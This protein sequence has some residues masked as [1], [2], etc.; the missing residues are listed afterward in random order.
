MQPAGL[1]FGGAGTVPASP[2]RITRSPCR[3]SKMACPLPLLAEPQRTGHSTCGATFAWSLAGPTRERAITRSASN[4]G[5]RSRYSALAV[6][7][8]FPLSLGDPFTT[9]RTAELSA[10]SALCECP[11]GLT[12]ASTVSSYSIGGYFSAV[13]HAWSRGNSDLMIEE[14]P[15]L[16]LGCDTWFTRSLL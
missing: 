7:A 15:R 16:C 5:S 14:I 1:R 13:K 2:S 4:A 9:W 12:F 11:D 6:A 3:A 10:A 8:A